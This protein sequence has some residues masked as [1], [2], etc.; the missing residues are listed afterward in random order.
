M[1]RNITTIG[2]LVLAG[3]LIFPLMAFSYGWGG[4]HYMM[5]YWGS[6][7]EYGR[8]YYGNLTSEQETKLEALD[9][10]FYD[11]TRELRDSILTKSSELEA[12]IGNSNPDIEKAKGLQKEIS[13][14]R[15][16][17]DEKTVAY[18]LEARKI[19]PD[20]NPGYGNRGWN[21][22]HMGSLSSMMGYGHGY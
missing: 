9:S 11:E 12:V 15:A 8:C 10:K 7:A 6:R 19:V 17:L 18:E 3:A 21:G 22:H 2:I 5:G 1:K 13:D 14:L 4:G 16:T 20:Q